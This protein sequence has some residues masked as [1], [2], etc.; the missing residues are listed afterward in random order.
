[1][2]IRQCSAIAFFGACLA[3]TSATAQ[4]APVSNQAATVFTHGAAQASPVTEVRWRG[5]HWRHRG[6]Y[7]HYGYYDDGGA[8]A[9]GAILGLAAG[10]IAANAAAGGGNAVAYCSQRFRSYDPAS[11]TYLGYDGYRHPCP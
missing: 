7:R 3:L 2:N 9:A 11:G 4:A 5:R 10:A 1:M 8:V 6:Y